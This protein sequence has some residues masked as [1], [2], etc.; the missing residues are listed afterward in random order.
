MDNLFQLLLVTETSDED[1]TDAIY[2]NEV[3]KHFFDISGINIQWITL[4]GKTHYKDKRIENKIKNLTKMYKTYT[5]GETITIF[6][7]DTD[8]PE[9]EYKQ[10]S[11]FC[12]LCDYIAEKGYELVWFCKN[13]ENVF[14]GVEASSLNNKTERA[15]EF[16]KDNAINDVDKERLSK[17][18]I[19]LN[20]S[21]ILIVL[22]KYL[23]KKK[24]WYIW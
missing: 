22:S 10:G 2:I 24:C 16:A 7:I 14:L 19:E 6:F 23:L 12:N 3:I 9:K 4:G 1:K 21:N 11:F 17:I 5:N 13:A 18:A 8:S 15:K 20:C